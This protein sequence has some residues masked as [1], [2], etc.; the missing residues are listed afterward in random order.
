MK[1]CF[2][3]LALKASYHGSMM[4]DRSFVAIQTCFWLLFKM[5]SCVNSEALK[6]MGNA[7][8]ALMEF[9]K[10]MKNSNFLLSLAK[11]S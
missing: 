6:P 2:Q 11:V 1:K 10:G 3:T 7:R 4:F 9:I 8:W 5:Q